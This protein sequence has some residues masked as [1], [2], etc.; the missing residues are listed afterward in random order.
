MNSFHSTRERSS[1]LPKD[2]TLVSVLMVVVESVVRKAFV[3]KNSLS[4]VYFELHLNVC[5]IMCCSHV[6]EHASLVFVCTHILFSSAFCVHAR[7]IQT[8]I[9]V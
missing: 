4:C 8:V 5:V 2:N 1:I 3:Y 9:H 6:C 7:F